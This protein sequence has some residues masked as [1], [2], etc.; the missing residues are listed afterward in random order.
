MNVAKA[1]N[2]PVSSERLSMPAATAP[3]I[4][5]EVTTPSAQRMR[6]ASAAAMASSGN[7]NGRSVCQR[8]R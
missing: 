4:V 7:R 3:L 5:S 8:I 2:R 1:R 6:T